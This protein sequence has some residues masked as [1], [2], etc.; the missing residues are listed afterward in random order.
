VNVDDYTDTEDEE[1][2][3][4]LPLSGVVMEANESY[5]SFY[6]RLKEAQKDVFRSGS[7]LDMASML[8][9]PDVEPRKSER[10]TVDVVPPGENPRLKLL[11]ELID[12]AT[13]K[14]IVFCRF[15][16]DVQNICDALGDTALRY[17]GSVKHGV[18]SGVLKRFRDPADSARVLVANVHAMSMGVTLT[19]AKTMIFYS[20]SFSLEKRLQA[21]DRF[22]R[23][24]QTD[25]VNVI[26][27]VA[28]GTVD[29]HLAKLLQEKFDV[30]AQVTGDRFREWIKP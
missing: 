11:L 27:I 25:S 16:R 15:K 3:P 2:E 21:E 12:M 6:Q 13:G 28:D 8:A 30:Q 1:A 7:Q 18:R 4:Q 29:L 5:E 10:R 20:N 22:H 24:G 9:P 14:I 17:D 19:I 26:D 23:I